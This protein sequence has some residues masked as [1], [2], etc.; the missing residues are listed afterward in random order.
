MKF[1]FSMILLLALPGVGFAQDGP[2]VP[3][4]FTVPEV[5]EH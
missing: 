4:N 5:L 1:N 2:F 3:G